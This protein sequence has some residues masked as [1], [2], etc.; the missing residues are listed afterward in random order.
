MINWLFRLLRSTDYDD[1]IDGLIVPP[2]VIFDGHD[3]DAWRGVQRVDALPRTHSN[4]KRRSI[5]RRRSAFWIAFVRRG[6]SCDAR[7]AGL[8]VEAPL[9]LTDRIVAYF[10]SH[11]N[12][13]I[14]GAE[15]ALIGGRYAWRTR[16]SDA[17][18]RGYAIENRKRTVQTASGSNV[19]VS[20]YR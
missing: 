2:R 8:H 9:S 12:V 19:V 14:D 18:Q 5:R 10:L 15:L 1:T 17:R 13:W 11:Q 16:V 3:E 20:E 6:A 7:G 4:A